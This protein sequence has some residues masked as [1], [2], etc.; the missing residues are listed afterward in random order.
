MAQIDQIHGQ[1]NGEQLGDVRSLRVV[2]IEVKV[3]VGVVMNAPRTGQ[4]GGNVQRLP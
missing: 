2:V 1:L 4:A 3:T